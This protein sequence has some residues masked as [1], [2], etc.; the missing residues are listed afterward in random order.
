MTWKLGLHTIV[1]YY[2]INS[3]DHVQNRVCTHFQ[4]SC[5]TTQIHVIVYAICDIFMT[6]YTYITTRDFV[7]LYQHLF[8][9]PFINYGCIVGVFCGENTESE[10]VKENVG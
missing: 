5:K 8:L 2:L 9:S 3:N 6:C 4:C 10:K 7:I 1:I